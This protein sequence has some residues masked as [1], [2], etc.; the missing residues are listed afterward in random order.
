MKKS[1]H[2]LVLFA[3]SL[4]LLTSSVLLHAQSQLSATEQKIAKTIDQ[5]WG[6]TLSLL[7]Q[8]VD[9]NSGTY[10]IKGV[11]AVGDLYANELR[12][13]GFTVE[14]VSLPDSM[15][16]AGH[17]VAYRKGTQGKKLF[18]IGHLDT[19]F[20]PDMPPNPFT[21]LNDSTATGQGVN[22]MKGGDVMIIAALKA[23]HANSLL[24]NTSITVY[25]TGDEE[26]AGYPREISRGD[27]ISRAKKHDIALAFETASGLQTIATARRGASG[28]QLEV[29]GK[30][31]HSSGVFGTAG[32]GSI[33]EAARIINSFRE[34]LSK[35]QYLTFNPGLIIGGS[36]LNYNEEAQQGQVS[37]KTNIISPRT[38]AN[39]DL[40]FISEEQ[41]ENARS[42][43]REI[44]AQ[45][46][47]GTKATIR[48]VDGIPSM[49]PTEGNTQLATQLSSVSEAMGLG[50]VNPGN[51]GSRGA[52]DISYVAQYLDC[53][54]GLGASG[55]GAH[56]P[57]ETINLYEY[58]KLTQR[59]AVFI[60]RL[61][62]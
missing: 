26:N 3:V 19:V 30:Q 55:R 17:L 58:P 62:R 32:Y 46:L 60:Y 52:G 49:P 33:F 2:T 1:Y 4:A 16:R 14:W 35:E 7:Q 57:G 21:K 9:I 54:D 37:G 13:L 38:V 43:M 40:R 29:E 27:F 8:S 6:S 11:R 59:A 34:R 22:D 50:K 24:D 61:T 48:F 53:L 28:W 41:K 25:M 44:V 12:A 15:Q 42:V 39:G 31:A 5:Q 45:S 36:E 51:P 23:L 18:L 10:N 56:A 20:E 47:P